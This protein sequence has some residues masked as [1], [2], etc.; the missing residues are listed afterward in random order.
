MRLLPMSILTLLLVP[1]LSG[2]ADK[3]GTIYDDVE[4]S[5]AI[6]QDPDTGEL[7]FMKPNLTQGRWWDVHVAANFDFGFIFDQIGK[8]VVSTKDEDGFTLGSDNQEIGVLD[9]YFD[10]FYVGRL[11]NDLNP[12]IGGVNAKFFQWPLKENQ[13]WTSPFFGQGFDSFDD[14]NVTAQFNVSAFEES[15][16]R[17]RIQGLTSSG[18]RLDYDYDADTGWMTYFRMINATGRIVIGLDFAATGEGFQGEVHHVSAAEVFSA[19]ELFPFQPYTDPAAT[20]TVGD[21]V[22]FVEEIE[23]LFTY[24]V[25]A[26]QIHPALPNACNGGGASEI[27]I[28]RPDGSVDPTPHTGAGDVFMTTFERTVVTQGFAGEWKVAFDATGTGGFFLLVMAFSDDV[29]TL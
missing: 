27:T 29:K 26:N 20:F 10:S 19:F 6:V 5:P 14:A 8:I 11:D 17:L 1:L 28:M 25:C 2:C 16:R 12:T 21:G 4:A 24:P 23:F 22:A 18:E 13:T 3:K 15:P 9:S 7:L